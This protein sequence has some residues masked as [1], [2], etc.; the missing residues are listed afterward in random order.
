M[1]YMVQAG[2]E[3]WT[4]SFT[5]LQANS[6]AKY[7]YTVQW[8]TDSVR[9][10][11]NLSSNYE[12]FKY[13]ALAAYYN[14][15]MWYITGDVR[16]AQKCVQIF[17]AMKNIRSIVSATES[18][19]A[20]RVIWKLLEGAEII[21]NTYTG[22]QQTDIDA[23]KAMLVYPGYSTSVDHSGDAEHS[24]YW[25]MFNGDF[26]RHGNQGLFGIRGIMAMG[27]FMD[28]EIM[29]DRALRYLKGQAHR[30]DDLPYVSGPTI[31]SSSPSA[32]N[33]Y[34]DTY[35]LSAPYIQSTIEDY[36]Y[37]EVIKNYIWENGQS[38]ESSRDQSHALLG[39]SIINTMCE[40]AW[41]QGED[42][43]SFLN[44]RPLLG[45]EFYN[46]YN[47]SYNFSF[48]DQLTSWE[49]TVS[50]GEFI[51]RRDRSARWYSKAIN[52]Y[53]ESD[54][55][56]VTRGTFVTSGN[57]PVW[58]MVLGHYK[59]RL[60]LPQSQY[61]WTVR[62]D[63]ISRKNFGYEQQGFQVDH[64]GFGGLTFHRVDNCP[65]DPCTF[66]NRQ[67]V[68]GIHMLP[69]KVEA[70]DFDFFS[71]QGQ[72]RTFY[73]LSGTKVANDYRPDS[74]VTIKSCSAGG[75]KVSDMA[76]GEWLAY[77][78]YVPSTQKY[79]IKVNYSAPLSGSRLKIALGGTDKTTE[80]ALPST[81]AG[82]WSDYTLS[83][84]ASLT[85]GI[86]DLRAYVS[87]VSNNLELNSIS[88]L[89]ETTAT[90]EVRI[91]SSYRVF[92][93]ENR[94]YINGV[95]PNDMLTVFAIN[96]TQVRS[97]QVTTDPVS[98]S[99]PKGIY[100]LNVQSRDNSQRFKVVI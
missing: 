91:S 59:S 77:T 33:S 36:G 62:C 11:E 12:K 67:P 42:I 92:T 5:K 52:P 88:I 57:A 46:H 85:S 64:P 94:I 78:V 80:I 54:F 22:W 86:Q 97:F 16:H 26:G 76:A 7:T 34:F 63:S 58:E 70:E 4:S 21:K 100:I 60:N 53:S 95:L 39:V 74:A 56:N 35:T 71:A 41:N 28:N 43:Y 23:F 49:P 90:D 50:T 48:T 93:E 98:F 89:S 2:K 81:G 13:D 30:S 82:I 51:Q 79:S 29:F 14:S 99:L 19:G 47:V 68:Y 87:G 83:G 66:V 44:Y 55:V 15:L 10:V 8:K 31:V 18:L 72:S 20:G 1:K 24:F 25:A 17:N 38:Q 6:Y 69:G 27:I 61:K 73:E 9:V 84:A 37:N 65:G 75:Y 40:M 32:T 96:G 3:P 45:L